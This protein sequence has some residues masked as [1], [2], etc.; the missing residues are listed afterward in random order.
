MPDTLDQLEMREARPAEA[1]AAPLEE[2]MFP[3]LP[4]GVDIAGVD[5]AKGVNERNLKARMRATALL[6]LKQQGYSRHEIGR[7]LGMT[8]NAVRVALN[9]A[10]QAGRL[11]D[12]R[13]ILENDSLALAI[14]GLNFHLK[15]KDKE[16]VF[17][18][19]EGLGQFRNYN[20]SKM[21][22]GAGFT[23]PA[24]S[25]TIVNAPNAGQQQIVSSPVG[26]PRED[27]PAAE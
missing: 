21:E 15:K 14:E 18:T 7:M 8:A 1:P 11:N 25:V 6:V 16:A 12:L 27:K 9:R 5:Y 2:V 19:L 3:G 26:V 20:N 13:S 17:K 23:M 22:G 24:L 10:R 4:E